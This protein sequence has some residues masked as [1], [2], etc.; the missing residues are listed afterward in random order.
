MFLLLLPVVVF[1]SYT[2]YWQFAEALFWLWVLSAVACVGRGFWAF[3]RDRLIGAVCIG[4][5]FL[6]VMFLIVP[7]LLRT[8]RRP[9]QMSEFGLLGLPNE[10]S[11][12][13][14]G[15]ASLLAFRR[16]WPGTTHRRR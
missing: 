8:N 5:V 10:H 13:D 16:P 9:S 12:V 4:V 2:E 1:W 7:R 15:R 6:Q 3:R 14:V 11:G